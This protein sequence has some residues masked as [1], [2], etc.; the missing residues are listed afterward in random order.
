MKICGVIM[1]GGQETRFGPI[2]KYL[3]S[4]T[5]LPIDGRDEILVET[6]KR[7]E[8]IIDKEDIY[9]ITNQEQRLIFNEILNYS[10]KNASNYFAESNYIIEPEPKGT[11]ACILYSALYMKYCLSGEE[12]I[13][14][15]FP[16]DHDIPNDKDNIDLFQQTLKSAIIAADTDK[17]VLI[18]IAPSFSATAYGYIRLSDKDSNTEKYDIVTHFEEKPTTKKATNYIQEGY[19]WNSGIFIW[20]VKVILNGYLKYFKD[21]YSVLNEVFEKKYI[22][23]SINAA[24]CKEA[25]NR[26]EKTS[27]DCAILTYAPYNGEVLEIAGS[28]RW[29]DIGKWDALIAVYSKNECIINIDLIGVDL[30]NQTVYSTGK[31]MYKNDVNF[32]FNFVTNSYIWLYCDEDN[33]GK[34]IE[35]LSAYNCLGFKSIRIDD[36]QRKLIESE[37][38]E[39]ELE[40]Q[41]QNEIRQT[42]VNKNEILQYR[43][44]RE[45]IFKHLNESALKNFRRYEF[46]PLVAVFLLFSVSFFAF[47]SVFNFLTGMLTLLSVVLYFVGKNKPSSYF[48]RVISQKRN[49]YINNSVYKKAKKLGLE[50]INVHAN[51]TRQTDN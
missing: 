17:I 18:G 33:K 38:H 4:K 50:L 34:T 25:Y 13:M 32:T 6:I 39:N 5:S 46:I 48:S 20:K 21:G 49:T 16:S 30:A 15:V 36:M 44:E 37:I 27:V 24:R 42:L 29:Q 47:L 10:D 41:I 2:K 26:I 11:A 8:G 43:V 40:T 31:H 51:I 1:A 28:F 9:I 23:Y 3:G 22:D 45:A 14:C 12:T 19:Q 35:M 7:C